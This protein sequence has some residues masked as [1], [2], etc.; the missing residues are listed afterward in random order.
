MTVAKVQHYVPQF[1]LRGFG[2]GKKDQVWVYDKATDRSFSTNA[3]NIASES[4]F[5][6]FE[7]NGELVTLEPM[8]SRLEGGA[9]S[10]IGKILD[11]DS[12]ASLSD[13]DKATMAVFLSVQLARTKA[14][15]A[16]WTDFPKLLRERLA[17]SGEEVAE[18]SQA[19][20]LIRDL[21]KTNP[22]SKQVGL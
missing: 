19:A 2:N 11:A 10:V 6:D 8:L 7:L 5:Y 13:E 12:V 17:L 21:T 20:E 3:K 14:F 4:R 18:G 9:K 1:L 16:Q 22:K 15:R